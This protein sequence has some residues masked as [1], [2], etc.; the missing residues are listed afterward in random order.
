MPPSPRLRP[1][2]RFRRVWGQIVGSCWTRTVRSWD[3]WRGLR[4][5]PR[6]HSLPSGAALRLRRSTVMAIR[7]GPWDS[8]PPSVPAP[9]PDWYNRG[10]GLRRRELGP[11]VVV[12]ACAE[13]PCSNAS[14][15]PE[16]SRRYQRLSLRDVF[17]GFE[18]AGASSACRHRACARRP[19]S[20]ALLDSTDLLSMRIRPLNCLGRRQVP[21]GRALE[22]GRGLRQRV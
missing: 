2:T 6:P 18:G 21:T 15:L 10:P 1:A 19:A 22:D 16:L 5:A 14:P 20:G 9:H 17:L 4:Q 11:R 3:N 13:R 8:R 7:L 12:M